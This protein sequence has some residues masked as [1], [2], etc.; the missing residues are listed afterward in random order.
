VKPGTA[1]FKSLRRN[2]IF[3]WLQMLNLGYRISGVV[4]TD[5][6]YNFH[7]TG[8]I[9]NYIK[10][11]TDDPAK[12]DT[13]EMVHASERGNVIMTNGPFLDVKVQAG[14]VSAIPGN[15]LAAP[16]GKI[17]LRV[18]VQCANWYDID[19]VQVFLNGK[20][21]EN[22]NFTRREK[23]DLFGN[24][25]IKFDAEIPV[26]LKEDSHVIVAA[27][28]EG[29]KM[30]PV[31]GPR[32][33]VKMPIA[34]SNPVFVDVDGGGFQPNGDDLGVPLPIE[35]GFRVPAKAKD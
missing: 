15:D 27:A 29:L 30:G 34:V 12:I 4:N 9:R 25:V 20:Q 18:R 35:D 7:D 21:A 5:A 11:P 26:E 19:R 22:L 13:M 33:S 23:S 10:S 3:T 16:D 28:G 6:H 14:K 1:E 32:W 17:A 2:P 31:Q 8:Y 24:G